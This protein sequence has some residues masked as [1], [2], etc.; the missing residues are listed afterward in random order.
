MAVLVNCT[1]TARW[2]LIDTDILGFGQEAE[3][4][5]VRICFRAANILC[6]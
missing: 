3:A 2:L 4:T 5:F 1:D 6:G